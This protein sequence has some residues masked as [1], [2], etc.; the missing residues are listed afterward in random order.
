MAGPARFLGKLYLEDMGKGLFMTTEPLGFYSA[1]L[2]TVVQAPAGLVTDL[3]SIPPYVP[4]W[5]VP[6]LGDYDYAAI[7]HDA[8]YKNML[9]DAIGNCFSV[10]KSTADA[11]FREG[12]EARGVNKF[13][14]WTMWRMVSWFGK[15]EFGTR[16]RATTA[17]T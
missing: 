8:A 1:K 12:M 10:N 11:L 6:K 2:D 17:T 9:Q 5:L 14:R 16:C 13:R 4:G 3:A 7:I 15:G